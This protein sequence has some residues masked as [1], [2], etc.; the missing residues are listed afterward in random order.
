MGQFSAEKPVP[1]GSTLE[2]E[3]Q[4]T[5][6]SSA[7]QTLYRLKERRRSRVRSRPGDPGETFLKSSIAPA[8]CA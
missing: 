8:A 2:C 6:A 7:N 1:P 4:Q 3:I 5:R